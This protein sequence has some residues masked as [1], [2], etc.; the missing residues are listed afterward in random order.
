MAAIVNNV[1][2]VELLKDEVGMRDNNGFTASAW[3]RHAGSR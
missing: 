2:V 1:N 3:A